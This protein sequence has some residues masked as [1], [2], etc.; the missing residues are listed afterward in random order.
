MDFIM[1]RLSAAATISPLVYIP[2]LL[3]G[4]VSAVSPCFVPILTMFGGY[5]GGYVRDSA[6]QPPRMAI[7]FTSG[8]ALT[9]AGIG[10]VAVLVGKSVLSLFHGIRT[11]SL[12]PGGHRHLNGITSPGLLKFRFLLIGYL[13]ARQ[14]DST[15]GA[16]TLGLPF[17]L[18]VTPCTIPIFLTIVTYLALNANVLHGALL[19]V[20]YALGRGIVL[21]VVA[22]STSIIKETIVKQLKVGR[23]G[24]FVER[25]IGNHHTHSSHWNV[26]SLF[27][28]P[29]RFGL[30]LHDAPADGIVQ[31]QPSQEGHAHVDDGDT[32][33]EQHHV[34]IFF[35]VPDVTDDGR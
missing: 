3:G 9:L 21:V 15:W 32:C 28:S 23:V 24:Q 6:G 20:A 33:R 34:D 4:T 31:S 29:E 14:P 7:A 30:D 10:V 16:F 12:H 27:Q 8:Q 13:R 22:Y 1:E 25:L 11:G 26:N 19:M 18:V 5:V 2:V 17:G 35:P